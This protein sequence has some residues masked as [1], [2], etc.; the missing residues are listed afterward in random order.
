MPKRVWTGRVRSSWR[1]T[2]PM[3]PT[4][5]SRLSLSHKRYRPIS[6]RLA[7]SAQQTSR[8]SPKSSPRPWIMAMTVKQPW[9]PSKRWGSIHTLRR[10]AKGTLRWRPRRATRQRQRRS[11]W[12]RRFAPLQ[13]VRCTHDAK[14]LWSQCLGRSKQCEGSAA[15]CCVA[16]KRCVA[17]GLWCA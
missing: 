8:A 9:R 7:S 13:V 14:S 5:N 16:C 11:V 1:V 3:P 12:R 17:N 10:S 6:P 15:S 4:T 2:S